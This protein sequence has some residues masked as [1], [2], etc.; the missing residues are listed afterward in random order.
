MA[1]LEQRLRTAM[2]VA[3]ESQQ[4][5]PEVLIT[6]VVRRHRRRSV[7]V[8]C[9]VLL[10]A[11]AL[12]VPAVA[13]LHGAMTGP[14]PSTHHPVRHSRHLPTRLTGVPMP[15]GTSLR[16]PIMTL[17][18]QAAWYSTATRTTTRIAGLPA[19]MNSDMTFK[20][21]AGGYLVSALR[22][23]SF[24]QTY[25]CAGPPYW[26]FFVA[27]GSRRATRVGTAVAFLGAVGAVHGNA[28]WLTSYAHYS[29]D[30]ATAAGSVRLVSTGGQPIGP[31]YRLPAGYRLTAAVGNDFLLFKPSAQPN[32]GPSP[33]VSLLWDPHT[34]QTVRHVDN[35]IAAS[36]D[37]V[38]WT[39][40]CRSCHVQIL[41]VA[42]GVNTATP[43]A[44][45]QHDIGSGSFSDNGQ[46]FAYDAV[47]GAVDILTLSTAASLTVVPAL[48]NDDAAASGW[49]NG[50]PTFLVEVSVPYWRPIQ[51]AIWQP[52]DTR[53]RVA[54]VKNQAAIEG[55]AGG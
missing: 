52:G 29:D 11:A 25:D 47:S 15:A 16:V 38:A 35:A 33:E 7:L 36:Q 49:L 53:L 3:A 13:I 31:A 21:A 39:R 30:V 34:G 44:A 42:T 41:N 2:R 50:G 8:V 54:S 46:Y 26:Y 14:A 18:G 45:S 24:C 37:D 1:D 23:H 32:S 22:I 19:T 5:A 55:W 4:I 40:G 27:D 28:V 43:L 6:A 10:L 12:S 9:M 51:F 20:R 17:T 48:N